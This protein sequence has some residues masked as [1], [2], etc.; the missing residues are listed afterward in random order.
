MDHFVSKQWQNKWEKESAVKTTTLMKSEDKA[1]KPPPFHRHHLSSLSRARANAIAF[2]SLLFDFM[3]VGRSVGRGRSGNI[4]MESDGES[5]PQRQA[6]IPLPS[7]G[8]PN[9]KH[10]P[11]RLHNIAR[12][13]RN[14][15]PAPCRPFCPFFHIRATFWSRAGY[16]PPEKGVTQE[17]EIS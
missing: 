2:Y 11:A 7:Q 15:R 5:G 10:Y 6:N 12:K 3:V 1:R 8:G 4:L 13:G 14:G 16:R 17:M 9:L